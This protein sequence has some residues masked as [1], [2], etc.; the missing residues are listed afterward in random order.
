MSCEPTPSASTD[1]LPTKP[2][3]TRPAFRARLL[4]CGLATLALAA[5]RG[6]RPSSFADHE[7]PLILIK[8]AGIPNSEPWYTHFAKHGWFDVRAEP[9]GSWTRVEIS[10]PYSGVRIDGIE[11]WQALA[12]ERWN[13]RDVRVRGVLSGPRAREAARDLLERAAAYDDDRYRA[14]P[15]PNSNTFVAA[16]VDAVPHL[17]TTQ[18]HNAVGKDFATPVGFARTPSKTGARLDTPVIGVALAL[19]EGVELH[20]AGLSFGVGLWP[21]RLEIPFVPEIGPAVP[22]TGE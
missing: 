6:T 3:P 14:I 4:A 18:H 21:P 12:D 11:E 9:G 22:A 16:L 5:C 7:G 2:V 15:G 13:D 8:E 19:Q 10:S 17:R 1:P 20:L